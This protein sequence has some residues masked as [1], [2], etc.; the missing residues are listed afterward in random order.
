MSPGE[1]NI[2]DLKRCMGTMSH[3][4][5]IWTQKIHNIGTKYSSGVG[6]Q[7]QIDDDVDV[8]MLKK[9]TQKRSLFSSIVYQL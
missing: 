7:A 3:K 9:K 8:G 5:D 1:K 2:C 4:K 6:T